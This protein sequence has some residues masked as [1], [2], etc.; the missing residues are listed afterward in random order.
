MT[1]RIFSVLMAVAL[2]FSMSVLTVASPNDP[3]QVF[4]IPIITLPIEIEPD[5]CPV[6][7]QP[8]GNPGDGDC[9]GE[10]E[11]N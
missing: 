10:D 8:P 3:P 6:V 1:K 11:D 9:Q 4:S 2:I 5:P 7:V